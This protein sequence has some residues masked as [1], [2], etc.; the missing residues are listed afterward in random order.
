LNKMMLYSGILLVIIALILGLVQHFG[1]YNLYGDV[2]NKWYFYGLV[3][4]IGVIGIV[5]AIW[6]YMQK[7]EPA[8]T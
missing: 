5:L 8:K 4:V 3:G 7:Q 6:T 2:G 1:V